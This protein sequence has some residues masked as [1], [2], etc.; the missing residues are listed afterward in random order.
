MVLTNVSRAEHLHRHELNHNPKEVY[1]C[2]APGCHHSFVRQ[3]LFV[4]HKHRHE[5]LAAGAQRDFDQ[6]PSEGQVDDGLSGRG[7]EATL[8]TAPTDVPSRVGAWKESNPS[9][10]HVPASVEMSHSLANWRMHSRTP[11]LTPDSTALNSEQPPSAGLSGTLAPAIQSPQ[12]SRTMNVWKTAD[13]SA[14]ANDNF[15]AWLFE[16]P[17]SQQNE[18]DLNNMSF[19]D[20]GLEYSP[21]DMWNL[22]DWALSVEPAT[23]VASHPTPGSTKDPAVQEPLSPIGIS[24]QRREDVISLLQHFLSKQRSQR[25]YATEDQSRLLYSPD[26]HTLPNLSVG[27]LDK[28]TANYWNNVDQQMSIV[29]QPSFSAN[30]CNVLLLL[31]IIM[32][33][34]ADLVKRKPRGY[35]DDHKELAETI[36]IQLRWEIFTDPDAQPPV[37]LWVAQALLLL[38]YYEKQWSSRRLHERAHIHHASTLTL[39]RRGSPLVGRSDSESPT[40]GMPTRAATPAV[41]E[42]FSKQ[43]VTPLDSW[44]MHWVRN[45]SF[46]RVVF[47]AFQMDTLHAVMYGHAADM[48]PYEIRLPLPCDESLWRATNAEEVHRLD[49]NLK[50]YGIKPI[51]FLDGLK[52]CLHAHDVQTHAPAR[53][54]LMA[55]L[56]SVGWHISRREK[57]L[58]FLETV[59]SMREQGRWRSLLLQAFGH[60]RQSFDDAVGMRRSGGRNDK[61][62]DATAPTVLFHLAHMTMHAGKRLRNGTKD[63][64]S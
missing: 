57:H 29:H 27:M 30:R 20:F 13:D 6:P 50:M 28:F 2:D 7:N 51:H 64:F 22:D 42:P 47:T 18:F 19:L 43:S 3:D 46:N 55:G 9:D 23:S 41:D 60:W 34:A 61:N 56:L 44:W 31:A 58:Q 59:P 62:T 8:S 25:Q 24:E 36:A 37:Q 53:M 10:T 5:E 14:Q 39:L 16:S 17:G 15:A 33:G 11:L 26:S 52:R 49:A 54:L 45:E 32:L 40:S 48:A 35:L 38:E 4:R 63:S 21:K 1:H 12:M